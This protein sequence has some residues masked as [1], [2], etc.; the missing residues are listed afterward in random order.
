MSVQKILLVD[1]DPIILS[2]FQRL[3]HREENLEVVATTSPEEAIQK[4]S[5][6]TFA[7]I[8]SDQHMP[9]MEGTQLLEKAREL[10]PETIRIILTGDANIQ[11]AL[12]AINRGEV[13]R[14]LTKPWNNDELRLTVRQAV[15]QFELVIENKV[16]NELTQK[17][18]LELKDLNQNLEGKVVER[19]EKITLLNKQ[20][21]K[22]FLETVE[23]LA[24]L[25]E[26]HSTVIGNHSKRVALL[27]REIGA[28]MGIEG[29]D[30]FNLE[31]AA[32]LH[33]IGKVAIHSSILSKT[34]S[35]LTDYEKDVL[36]SHVIKGESI[37]RRIPSFFEASK[38]L[39]HHH[40]RMDGKGY[41]EG[42]LGKQIPLASR[43]IAVANV[44]DKALNTRSVFQS[45]TPQQALAHTQGR[46]PFELDPEIVSILVAY[47]HE[48]GGKEM[49]WSEVEIGVKD[50]QVGMVLSRELR[51][52]SGMLLLAKDNEI[53]EKH[54]ER[55]SNF[56]QTDPVVDSIFVFRK[57]PSQKV[58]DL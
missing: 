38:V 2:A 23:V 12:E 47:I 39:R 3:L 36:R 31:I 57:K 30:L 10:A 24:G 58:G 28:R 46:C 14:F 54:L 56:Q 19:T 7:V 27:V 51:T 55:V 32:T 40:E 34:E 50:L 45:A 4:I 43:I 15:A 18:N 22:S 17:Q 52:V 35:T 25:S 16:L 37:I 48:T 33:D 9:A 21:E 13:Y 5:T 11:A 29:K 49:E 26:M 42:L 53:G 1:D 20:L 41:P 6:E 8:L 44:F